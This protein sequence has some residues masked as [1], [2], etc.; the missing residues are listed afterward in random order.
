[1]NSLK[2]V[3]GSYTYT[4]EME[5]CMDFG[6]LG[7][8]DWTDLNDE[9]LTWGV[10]HK[11]DY[12]AILIFLYSDNCYGIHLAKDGVPIDEI[13]GTDD[14]EELWSVV[15]SNLKYFDQLLI[16]ERGVR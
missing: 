3:N 16:K 2:S 13:F 6:L 7:F 8:D 5:Y 15:R 11:R 9:G 1:M 4:K 10:Q 14:M 12:C